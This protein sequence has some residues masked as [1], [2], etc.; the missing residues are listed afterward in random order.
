M[1]VVCYMSVSGS[2]SLARLHHLQVM[3]RLNDAMDPP[4]TLNA[5]APVTA[6]IIYAGM[7]LAAYIS[8]LLSSVSEDTAK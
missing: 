2:R 8:Y 1:D 7:R 4:A 6:R 3:K 5:I